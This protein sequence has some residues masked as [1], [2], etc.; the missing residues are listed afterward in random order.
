MQGWVENLQELPVS[1]AVWGHQ[2]LRAF[3]VP[4][5][6]A[7]GSPPAT[8]RKQPATPVCA[9]SSHCLAGTPVLRCSVNVNKL[10][11]SFILIILQFIGIFLVDS[12][13][14]FKVILESVL[15][16]A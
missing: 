3:D 2:R 12:D 14:H 13:F 1:G 8:S 11:G 9:G 4:A 10:G 5:L 7:E 15:S 6:L 16:D